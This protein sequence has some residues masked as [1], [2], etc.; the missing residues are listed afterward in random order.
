[1]ALSE[2]SQRSCLERQRSPI[3]ARFGHNHVQA[4][5]DYVQDSDGSRSQFIDNVAHLANLTNDRVTSISKKV[6]ADHQALMATMNLMG[7]FKQAF[8]TM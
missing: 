7:Q 1:M 8:T 2:A 5:E 3:Y 4:L 6:D